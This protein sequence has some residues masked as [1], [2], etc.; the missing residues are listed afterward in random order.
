M[1]KYIST[2][3]D[4]SPVDFDEAVLQGFAQDG[5]LFIPQ[6]LPKISNEQLHKW[7]HLDY[8]SLAF[9]ILSL[10]IDKTIIPAT[11]LKRLIKSSF[12]NFEH[13]DLMPLVS[14]GNQSDFYIMELF[15]GP[16]LSFKDIAM[17][18]LVRTMDYLLK[19]RNQHLNLILATTGDTGPAAASASAGR[20][21]IDCWPLF[22][23]GMIS[24]EQERQMTT[25]TEQ[26]IHPVTVEDCPD[27]GDDLDIV[28][29]KMFANLKL[30]ND[31]KLSSVNSI[32]WCRVM[33]QTVHYAFAY[34]KACKTI[35]DPIAIS[36]PSGAFGNLCAGYMAREMGIP[37]STFICANNQNKTLHT[38][39]STGHFAKKDLIQTVSSAIDI[40]V[41]YNFWR[42]LYFNMGCDGKKTS[43]M[44]DS[45]QKD[46][47]IQLD[48][49]THKAIQTG[50]ESRTISDK[51]TLLTIKQMYE[52]YEY[53]LDP[54]GAVAVAAANQLQDTLDNRI[55][56]VCL[57]TAH[58]AKFPDIIKQAIGKNSLPAQ[59]LH[60]S[61]EAAKNLP[62]KKQTSTRINLEHFLTTQ[63]GNQTKQT[64]QS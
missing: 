47:Y 27:G 40:V 30:K 16:T 5:G 36:V 33:M 18:F 1:I 35:G 55:P 37:I 9:N 7:A 57:A 21:T 31:L 49:E 64:I 17:G 29:A 32:N 28:V 3:G 39:F 2:K 56:V 53:L 62:E 19:K 11:D 61:L 22:P 24:V 60:P 44:M 48:R 23:K 8:P 43:K 20:K 6:T 51:D 45:F 4:I 41:P 59:A 14:P 63:I 54:H 42:F 58:P 52:E 50:F 13:P 38:V 12:S 25:L 10:F 34:F 26:N 46:G 15:H